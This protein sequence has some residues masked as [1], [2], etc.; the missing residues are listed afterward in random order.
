MREIG[1]HSLETYS[2]DEDSSDGEFGV[3]VADIITMEVFVENAHVE[4]GSGQGLAEPGLE[5]VEAED[6]IAENEMIPPVYFS[7]DLL[8]DDEASGSICVTD[9]V[10]SCCHRRG[11]PL[12]TAAIPDQP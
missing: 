11:G 12:D 5:P 7:E 4:Q 2:V 10:Q 8:E 9:P 1:P 6:N 3:E